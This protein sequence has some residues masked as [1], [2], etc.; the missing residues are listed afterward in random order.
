MKP[1][2]LQLPLLFVI[3]LAISGCAT[4]PTTTAFV[5]PG[6]PALVMKASNFAFDPNSI[7]V[8]GTGTVTLT[9]TNTGGTGHNITINDP[10]GKVIDSAEIPPNGTITTQVTFP[11]PGD[12]PFTCNHPFHAGFGMKGHFVVSGS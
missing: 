3:A 1:Q 10:A 8:H 12:Y 7:T 9:I 2:K 4:V 11:A 5:T 6:G